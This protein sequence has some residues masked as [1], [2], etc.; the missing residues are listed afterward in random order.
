MPS[1]PTPLIL[2][3]ILSM[4]KKIAAKTLPWRSGM[5]VDFCTLNVDKI[6]SNASRIVKER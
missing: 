5:D 3:S 4:R 6:V 1:R 2:I